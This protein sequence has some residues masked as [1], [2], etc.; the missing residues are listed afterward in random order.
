M[1]SDAS[2]VA[3]EAAMLRNKLMRGVLEGSQL[4]EF[5]KNRIN[6]AA[7]N[8]EKQQNMVTP[9][10]LEINLRKLEMNKQGVFVSGHGMLHPPSAA[11]RALIAAMCSKL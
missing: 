7:V 3:E 5:S 1:T 11:M 9:A 4:T 8:L 10:F 6:W 2:A